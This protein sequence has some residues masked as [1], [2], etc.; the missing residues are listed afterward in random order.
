MCVAGDVGEEQ[1]R[2][3]G[4]VCLRGADSQQRQFTVAHGNLQTDNASACRGQ[5]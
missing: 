2:S 5:A 1:K 3:E 4:Q